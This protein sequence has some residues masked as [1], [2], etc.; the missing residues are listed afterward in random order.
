MFITKHKYM[1]LLP[2]VSY[3]K[4]VFTKTKQI[5]NR[6][7]LNHA[8]LGCCKYHDNESNRKV[9]KGREMNPVSMPKVTRFRLPLN[10]SRAFVRI[11]RVSLKCTEM[12]TQ[13]HLPPV[14]YRTM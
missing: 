12:S 6:K 7:Y 13:K 1:Y 10:S 14:K 4:D 8:S 5:Y 3:V 2:L 9:P 11:L